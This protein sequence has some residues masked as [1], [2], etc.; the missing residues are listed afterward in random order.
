MSNDKTLFL[1]SVSCPETVGLPCKIRI[2]VM[3]VSLK[4]LKNRE[5]SGPD[6][7]TI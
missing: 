7:R 5:G 1:C 2:D 4:V 6:T 3:E